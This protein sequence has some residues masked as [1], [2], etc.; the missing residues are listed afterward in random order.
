MVTILHSLTVHS[1]ASLLS[2]LQSQL[3]KAV[4]VRD[5]VKTIPDDVEELEKT[6]QVRVLQICHCL[7]VYTLSH[8]RMLLLSYI[9]LHV[10]LVLKCRLGI[11]NVCWTS[12][13]YIYSLLMR[14]TCM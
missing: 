11:P 9:K 14:A 2:T 8:A 6:L 5:I 1:C 10:V 13:V 12:R 4:E 3:E 7:H